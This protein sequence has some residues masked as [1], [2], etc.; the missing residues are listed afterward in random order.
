MDVATHSLK[1]QQ[2]PIL[3][4]PLG[5]HEHPTALLSAAELDVFQAMRDSHTEDP[6]RA[7]LNG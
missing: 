6:A 3:S 4:Q 5:A 7:S 1:L 2:T